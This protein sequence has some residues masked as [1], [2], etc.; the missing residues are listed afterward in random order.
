MSNW[1]KYIW[2]IPIISAIIALISL[3]VPAI[4][5]KLLTWDGVP[6]PS[7][8]NMWLI[9]YFDMGVLGEGWVDEI[10]DTTMGM[11]AID[12]LPFIIGVIGVLIGATLAIGSGILGARGNFRKPLALLGGILM[13]AFSII[14]TIWVE[15]EYSLFSGKTFDYM[16]SEIHYEFTVGF[17]IIGPII[18]GVLCIASFF[19]DRIPV[20][21]R[22]EPE[23]PKQPQVKAEPQVTPSS[24]ARFCPHCG[25]EV[26]GDFCPDCGKPFQPLI[27]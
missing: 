11:M 21:E 2:T 6:A 9:G 10:F 24:E 1:K 22:I 18:G 5:S 26:P 8:M 23:T 17:G 4:N 3:A 19:M 12:I 20:K 16:A 14:F 27:A 25:T 13:L 7:P 15:V